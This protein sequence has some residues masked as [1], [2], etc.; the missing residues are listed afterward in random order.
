MA[1]SPRL[2]PLNVQ[3]NGST[4]VSV[5]PGAKNNRQF[6]RQNLYGSARSIATHLVVDSGTGGAP[7]GAY[8]DDVFLTH[9][10]SAKVVHF[11]LA[12]GLGAGRAVDVEIEGVVLRPY[13]RHPEGDE[14]DEQR[15][16]GPVGAEEGAHG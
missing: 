6:L 11:L 5:V 7:A 4:E 9:A 3:A 13:E 15:E 12:R 16:Q 10:Q 8:G 2:V 14:H 1:T